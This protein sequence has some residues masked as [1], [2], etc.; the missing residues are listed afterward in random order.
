MAHAMRLGVES[1]RMAF[2]AGR[3]EKKRYANASSPLTDLI[4]TAK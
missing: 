3:M 4:G 1:G 2:L